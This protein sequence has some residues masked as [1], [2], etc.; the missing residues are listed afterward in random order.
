[1]LQRLTQRFPTLT[2]S[3]LYALAVSLACWPFWTGQF[4]INPWSDMRN[5]Y[6]VRELAASYLKQFGGIPEWT[7]YLFGGMPFIANTAHG[8]TFYPTFL[9]RAVLPV[10][11]GI[12]LGFMLHIALAGIFTFLFLRALKLD[13]GP[14]FIGG[15]A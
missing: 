14:S 11:V 1:M 4:L 12:T 7:P 3:G 5:G 9:L 2:A 13:W 8:D 6:P 15:A 10:D